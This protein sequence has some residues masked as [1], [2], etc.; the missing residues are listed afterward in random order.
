MQ[1]KLNGEARDCAEGHTVDLLLGT[2]G[3]D[4]RKVA[5][6]LNLAIVPRSC[7]AQTVLSDGDAVEIVRFIGGG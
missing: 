4:G 5:V 6:E 2:L 7:Y 1:I 3:L